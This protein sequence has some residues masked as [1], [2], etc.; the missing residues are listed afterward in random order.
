MGILRSCRRG[1]TY[2]REDQY[3]IYEQ[4]AKK[5]NLFRDNVHLNIWW[6][7]LLVKAYIQLNI[8]SAI[9]S[10]IHNASNKPVSKPPRKYELELDDLHETKTGSDSEKNCYESSISQQPISYLKKS[11]TIFC[12]VLI[13]LKENHSRMNR[14]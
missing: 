10:V 1:A 13:F 12:I 9:K 2:C 6:S 11:S 5:H 4:S 14:V 7:L 3:W 8:Y